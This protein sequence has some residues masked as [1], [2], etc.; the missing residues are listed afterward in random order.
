MRRADSARCRG[1][2]AGVGRSLT[3]PRAHRIIEEAS[4]EEDKVD[5]QLQSAMK[6]IDKLVG[7][8]GAMACLPGH[9]LAHLRVCAG[10]EWPK[11]LCIIVL[12]IIILILLFLL[13]T[14]K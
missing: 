10:A 12:F 13:I 2:L 6:K 5:S 11:Y 14:D 3:A 7:T 1:G 4:E 8:S 9:A